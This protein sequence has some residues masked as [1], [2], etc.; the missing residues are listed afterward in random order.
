MPD[1]LPPPGDTIWTPEQN[2]AEAASLIEVRYPPL[3]AW[4]QGEGLQLE[5]ADEG[6]WGGVN[7]WCKARGLQ[8]AL[9]VWHSQAK[10][11]LL[12]MRVT[13]RPKVAARIASRFA[14]AQMQKSAELI[15]P[16]ADEPEKLEDYPP[17]VA[18]V[19]HHP[20]VY[21]GSSERA[22]C[23]KDCGR[24]FANSVVWA[25][26]REYESETKA[27]SDAA[28]ALLKRCRENGALLDKLFLQQFRPTKD[29]K[30][31]KEDP[32][33][34]EEQERVSKLREMLAESR[35]KVAG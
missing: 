21:A 5:D 7:N 16:L 26:A 14:M 11:A 19:L 13:T 20:L 8:H 24:P 28:R 23:C 15:R 2:D 29:E 30:A 10:K 33:Q 4:L 31:E 1:Y 32:K 18:W 9:K 22:G 25:L 27:P 35:A 6:M 17:D 3:M 34:V 12:D